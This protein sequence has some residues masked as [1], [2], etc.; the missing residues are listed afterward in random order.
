MELDQM[1]K[2]YAQSK[3]AID[4]SGKFMT[5]LN[6]LK[7]DIKLLTRQLE[8]FQIDIIRAR[9]DGDTAKEKSLQALLKVPQQE[10]K[11]KKQQLEKLEAVAQKNQAT[12]DQKMAEISQDPALKAHLEEVIGKKFSRQLTKVAK[13]KD[14]KVKQNETLTKI[15]EA[16]KKDPNV[17]YTLKEI[18]K[19]TKSEAKLQSEI[20][21][22]SKTKDQKAHAEKDL[23]AVQSSLA[24]LRR[25]LAIY[26][27]GTVSRDVID[28]ITSYED[29]GREIKSNNKQIKGF[30]KQI[31]NYE[32]ALENIGFMSP[33]KEDHLPDRA[34]DSTSTSSSR[35]SPAPTSM[36]RTEP[37]PSNDLPAT[38]PK[39]YQFVKRFKNWQARRKADSTRNTDSQEPVMVSDEEKNKFKNSMKYEVVRDYE[40]QL[41]ANLL[42]QAKSQNRQAE[43]RE[44]DN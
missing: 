42:K 38:Q 6:V 40:E 3:K 26:F 17:M 36:P 9:E 11:A 25:D 24:N 14:E 1:D 12:V 30:D 34:N 29:L 44:I 4:K 18:E 37:A 41:A 8:N 35:T 31:A 23:L 32:T 5:T 10:L 43:D 13:S 16:A 21:D 15:Q 28:K 27:K 33:L 7:K 22:P 39:W 20:A 19:Y 2:A